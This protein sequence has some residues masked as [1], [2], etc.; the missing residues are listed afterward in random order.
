MDHSRWV[1][2]GWIA[3]AV[4]TTVIATGLGRQY[5]TNFTLPGTEAQRVTDLLR[6]EFKAQS[7]DVDTIVFH[8]PRG[9]IDAP[10]SAPP[11]PRCCP[12]WPRCPTWW[13]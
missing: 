9:S 13:A 8:N 11:L 4:I 7:G 6:S 5:A 10:A 12:V 2:V 3:V 1:L